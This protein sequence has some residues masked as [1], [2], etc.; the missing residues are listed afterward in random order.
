MSTSHEA[1]NSKQDDPPSSTEPSKSTTIVTANDDPAS[2]SNMTASTAATVASTTRVR[3][4]ASEEWQRRLQ[5]PM[6][7]RATYSNNETTRQLPVIP[8]I[9][10]LSARDNKHNRLAS[11]RNVDMKTAAL[12]SLTDN[13]ASTNPSNSTSHVLMMSFPGTD[14]LS[15][16]R[17]QNR[18][19]CTS[20]LEEGRNWLQQKGNFHKAID[21]FSRGLEMFP[22]HVDLLVELARAYHMDKKHSYKA[23]ALLEQALQIDPQHP[24]AQRL[25]QE[26]TGMTMTTRWSSSSSPVAPA[27]MAASAPPND[28]VASIGLGSEPMPPP[29]EAET[30]KEEEDNDDSSKQKKERTHKKRRHHN[31]GKHKKRRKRRRRRDDDHNDSSESDNDDDD[32]DDEEDNDENSS[33]S[34]SD[35]DDLSSERRRRRRRRRKK[36]HSEQK[37]Q[38][39]RERLRRRK[40]CKRRKRKRER[41]LPSSSSDSSSSEGDDDNSAKSRS[42]VDSLLLIRNE[43]RRRH[44][45]PQEPGQR[46]EIMVTSSPVALGDGGTRERKRARTASE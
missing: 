18:N 34:E 10:C 39:R 41:I 40:H 31:H 43:S 33:N 13:S 46:S 20:R 36:R 14:Y 45:Q 27:A 29:E 23:S 25:Y 44:R 8:W 3:S 7:V 11:E 9:L 32:D 17:L 35:N 12:P 1:H 30:E 15:L 5:D 4:R 24:Q 42:T 6:L 16:R 19:F 37:K 2:N 38:K 26:L 22:D 28:R 21:S